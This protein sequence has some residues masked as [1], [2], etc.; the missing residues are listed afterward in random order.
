MYWTQNFIKHLYKFVLLS[1]GMATSRKKCITDF[2][3]FTHLAIKTT[4]QGDKRR[5]IF[6]A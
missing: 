1:N 6:M 3:M 2:K 4:H 5:E